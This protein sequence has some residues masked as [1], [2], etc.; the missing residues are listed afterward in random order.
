M[1]L[2]DPDWQNED[3]ELPQQFVVKILTQ[4]VMQ[5]VTAEM[6]EMHNVENS[7]SDPKFK[8]QLEV[9]QKLCHNA[10]VRTYNHLMKIPEGKV[11]IPK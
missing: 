11:Q 8:E 10:E 2:I 6:S 3:K 5:K 9:L 7:F 4:L 1:V